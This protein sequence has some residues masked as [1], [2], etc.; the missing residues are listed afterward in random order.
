MPDYPCR[1]FDHLADFNVILV[2][3]PQR[4]GTTL[5]GHAISDEQCHYSHSA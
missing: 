1:M 4:S 5:V 2:T 3:G